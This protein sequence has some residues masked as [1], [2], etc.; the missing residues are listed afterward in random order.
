MNIFNPSLIKQFPRKPKG[1][2]NSVCVC[3]WERERERV[4]NGQILKTND[5]TEP[6]EEE[7]EEEDVGLFCMQN[8]RP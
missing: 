8:R 6:G 7:E 1:Q 4:Q 5:W 3:V 2:R